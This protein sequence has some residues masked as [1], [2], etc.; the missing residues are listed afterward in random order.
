MMKQTA[1]LVMAAL[2]MLALAGCGENKDNTNRPGSNSNNTTNG[3]KNNSTNDNND[4][5][6][7]N[8]TVNDGLTDSNGRSEE[9]R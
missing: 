5:D 7:D 8:G 6:K 1:A 3:D 9:R 2:L 4:A